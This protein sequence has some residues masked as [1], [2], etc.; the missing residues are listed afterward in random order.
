[1]SAQTYC[2]QNRIDAFKKEYDELKKEWYSTRA[3]FNNTHEN[4]TDVWDYPRVTGEERHG[5][6][7]PKPVEMIER[8]IKSSCPEDGACIEPFLGSGTTL[9]A[10]EKTG[11]VCYGMELSER[12]C[13]VILKRWEDF[14]GQEAVLI[15]E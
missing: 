12:Y 8:I 9:I 4:M 14:T 6:A 5:H 10:C 13:D 15:V 2:Q 1:M 3:Y 11:R 7:T